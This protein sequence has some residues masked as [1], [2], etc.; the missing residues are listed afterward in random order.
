MTAEQRQ[1]VPRAVRP[2]TAPHTLRLPLPGGAA[3]AAPCGLAQASPPSCPAATRSQDSAERTDMNHRGESRRLVQLLTLPLFKEAEEVLGIR[4][5]PSPRSLSLEPPA[6]SGALG[7]PELL[8]M[9]ATRWAGG[10]DRWL[11]G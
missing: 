6:S 10:V 11:S 8:A 1:R 3:L 5:T 7:A 2:V 9:P 4:K